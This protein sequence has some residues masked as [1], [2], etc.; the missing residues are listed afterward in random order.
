MNI[1]GEIQEWLRKVVRY[2]TEKEDQSKVEKDFWWA[3][4][5]SSRTNGYNLLLEDQKN[6]KDE[7]SRI[8]YLITSC[9]NESNFDEA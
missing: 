1:L 5:P 2:K 8:K 7:F 9:S 3:L 6:S 4:S